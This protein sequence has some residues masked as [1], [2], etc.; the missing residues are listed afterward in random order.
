MEAVREELCGC[1]GESEWIDAGVGLTKS[2][3]SVSTDSF[4]FFCL[5][6]HAYYFVCLAIFLSKAYETTMVSLF[7]FVSYFSWNPSSSYSFL[8]D[9][10]KIEI[11]INEF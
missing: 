11:Y 9:F 1:V 5:C 10:I 7:L 4:I 2:C 8:D 6:F 3:F